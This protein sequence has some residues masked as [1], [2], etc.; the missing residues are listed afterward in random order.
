MNQLE[1]LAA[2][3]GAELTRELLAYLLGE[4][5]SKPKWISA[6]DGAKRAQI[7]LARKQAKESSK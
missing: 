4:K 3:V 5:K 2:A 6:L 7:A 1:A